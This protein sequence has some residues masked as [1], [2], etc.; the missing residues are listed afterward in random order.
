MANG[1]LPPSYDELAVAVSTLRTR[2]NELEVINMVYHDNEQSLVHE[3]DQ[4]K[5]KV[6]ELERQ[7]SQAKAQPM[8]N[9]HIAKKPRIDEEAQKE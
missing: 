1:Q 4:L 9:D 6:E 8:E 2:V 3:R 5:R 7:L